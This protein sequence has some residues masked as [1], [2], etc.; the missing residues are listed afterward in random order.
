M[1]RQLEEAFIRFPMKKKVA[2]ALL[3]Y[4]LRVSRNGAIL[5]DEIEI[6][7]AKMARALDIDR[8]VVIETA[9]MIAG[10]DALFEF[11]SELR[12]TAFLG[13]AAKL[14]GFE[15][16]VIEADPHAT[17]IVSSV[18]RIT[19]KEGICIRQIVA[20]DPDIYP[21]PKLTVI[22]EKPLSGKAI[23]KLRRIKGITRIT[24]G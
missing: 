2:E 14:L 10:N 8:R 6:S 5:C 21:N 12:P 16:I 17:G 18:S 19:A 20:D 7:P 3:R 4:G 23:D 11:F 22:L 1:H 13:K 9:N 15:V 24:I